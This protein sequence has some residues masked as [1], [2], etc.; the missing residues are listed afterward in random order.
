MVI[1]EVLHLLRF[2]VVFVLR[3]GTLEELRAMK[4][5]KPRFFSLRVKSYLLESRKLLIVFPLRDSIV[6]LN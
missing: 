5:E 4:V 6:K 2:P 3:K 1:W